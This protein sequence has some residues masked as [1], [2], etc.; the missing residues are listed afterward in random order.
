MNH[1]DRLMQRALA[2]PRAAAPALFDPFAQEAVADQ[3]AAYAPYTHAAPLT[4]ASPMTAEVAGTTAPKPQHATPAPPQL[5]IAPMVPAAAAPVPPPLRAAESRAPAAVVTGPAPADLPSAV[6]SEPLSALARADQ[7]MRQIGVPAAVLPLAETSVAAPHA[8]PTPTLLKDPAPVRVSA[9]S[10]ALL[11]P[12][13]G[14]AA[15]ARLPTLEPEAPVRRNDPALR[16]RAASAR[17][18]APDQATSAPQPNFVHKPTPAATAPATT[19]LVQAANRSPW[20]GDLD[21]LVSS[22]PMARFGVGQ[23]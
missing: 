3:V 23:W 4:Q 20:S 12:A 6:A 9:S 17:P 13:P 11:Q 15:R 14:Q 10:P 8:K 7:F 18:A 16:P 2:L 22:T 21:R 5:P 1:F 19:V